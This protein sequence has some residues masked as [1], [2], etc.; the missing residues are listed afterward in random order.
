MMEGKRA[1]SRYAF[2]AKDV[3]HLAGETEDE[4][5]EALVQKIRDL[6]DALDIPQGIKNYGQYGV[7]ADESII[8]Y[9]EFESKKADV[10]ANAIL[11]ACTGSNPR[12]PT[13]EEMEQLL[14]CVYTDTP[15]TF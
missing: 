13:Q 10:A 4:L 2:I 15:V 3:L 6:N 5:V 11:D 8:D 7:K 9:D 14:E 1:K 12:I